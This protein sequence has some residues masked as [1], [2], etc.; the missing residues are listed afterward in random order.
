MG[1]TASEWTMLSLLLNHK[2]PNS[3]TSE[4]TLSDEIR[5]IGEVKEILNSLE[6][7]GIIK[8]EEVFEPS[9]QKRED[10]VSEGGKNYKELE[11]I[12]LL[13]ILGEIDAVE[14]E[15]RFYE[16]SL[17]TEIEN[18]RDIIP[19]T[20]IERYISISRLLHTAL[21]IINSEWSRRDS[22][23]TDPENLE[24]LIRRSASQI[25]E[26][27]FSMFFRYLQAVKKVVEARPEKMFLIFIYLY[28]FLRNLIDEKKT[29]IN[30]KERMKILN[31][32]E[33]L[34]KSIEVEKEIINVLKM[35]N[36]DE[37]KIRMHQDKLHALENK[38]H[39]ISARVE[40]EGLVVKFQR[41]GT[42][43]DWIKDKL[44]MTL[45]GIHSEHGSDLGR[46]ID[47]LSDLLYSEIFKKTLFVT[48]QDRD[49]L[50]N[51]LHLPVHEILGESVTMGS[52]KDYY[53]LKV[54][55]I[56][57]NDLCPVMLDSIMESNGKE[58]SMCKNPEC[59][60]VYHRKCIEKLLKTNV[61][62]CL[63]CGSPIT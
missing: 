43:F 10:K 20:S 63:V 60:V 38:F 4:L 29:L 14:Y 23:F 51:E 19:L 27:T 17:K 34:K 42:S 9:M 57:V 16:S 48:L 3:R 18:K 25:L 11:K 15:K 13:Y 6:R 47:D 61:A 35:L 46:F 31:E 40:K 36:E 41:S 7:K 44:M 1:V 58:L 54:S 32:M 21:T 55:L 52:E 30:K 59:F 62:T 24:S 8:I 33:E 28:P 50:Y 53:F 5:N 2:L 22:Q 26:K 45:G 49:L 39:E 37:Q 56:W 12:N